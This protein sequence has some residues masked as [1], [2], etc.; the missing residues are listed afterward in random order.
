M[1]WM[2]IVA[3]VGLLAVAG[4]V[5]A[6]MVDDEVVVEEE[7]PSCG[8]GCSAGQICSS[9]GCGFKETGSCGCGK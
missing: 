6:D 3:V 1:K 4:F 5:V 8:G 7:L 2:L 9:T